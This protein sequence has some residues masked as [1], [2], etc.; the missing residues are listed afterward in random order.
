[1][2]A[3][4]ELFLARDSW[5]NTLYENPR[6]RL[7][8]AEDVIASMQPLDAADAH[9]L[10]RCLAAG[11]MGL[12]ELGPDGQGFDIEDKWA[13][14]ASAEVLTAHRRPLLTHSTEP[15]GHP[16]PGKGRTFPWR[17]LKL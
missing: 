3:D 10:E 11:L 6:H 8:S 5:F 9:E 2:R 1:M 12:G 14:E 17:L 4:R 13:L 7:A 15:L 16:Y